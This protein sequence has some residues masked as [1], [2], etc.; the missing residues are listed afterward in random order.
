M[1][2]TPELLPCPFC[3]GDMMYRKALWPSDGDCDAIIH[4]VQQGGPDGNCGLSYFSNGTADGQ[5]ID[6]WQRA[7]WNRRAVPPLP[8][9]HEGA[10]PRPWSLGPLQDRVY[11]PD[12]ADIMLLWAE[13]QQ[14]STDHANAALIVAAVNAYDPE[15]EREGKVKAL[16][17]AARAVSVWDSVP[18]DDDWTR[19][20]DALK[21]MGE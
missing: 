7:V 8:A 10:T 1:T 6:A 15:R 13:D 2:D 20:E 14:P 11:G 4:K 12:G 21:A 19:L 5:I 16:V 9:P 17:E 18:S 3:G